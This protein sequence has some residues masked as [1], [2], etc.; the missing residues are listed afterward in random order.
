[1]SEVAIIGAGPT[2]LACALLLARLGVRSTVIERNSGTSTH[3]R[4]HVVNARSL[5]I[6]RSLG[7][8]DAIRAESLPAQRNQGVA[9]LRRLTEPAIAVLRT[10]GVPERD[11]A[12]RA[13]S[14][15]LRASCP[16]DRL[17]PILREAADRQPLIDLRFGTEVTGITQDN[18]SVTLSGHGPDGRFSLTASYLV[19]AD[20][21]RSLVREQAGI[22]MHGR[23]R[24]GRQIGI[25]F[26]ADLWALVET[27][28]YLLW[29]IY[30]AATCGVLI[31][32]DGRTRWTYNFA[33][34]P[35][36]ETADA[37]TP[38][39]CA[40]ILRHVIGRE[41]IPLAIRSILPWRMQALLA[42]QMGKG[43]IFVA[44]DAAHPLPP[45]GG[46]GMNT[47]IGDVHNLAWKLAL[48]LRGAAPQALLETYG[49]E[50]RPIAH[51]NIEQS[52][53]NAMKMAELGLSGMATAE[54][55]F[56]L[57]LDGPD[58]QAA[59]ERLRQA[60]PHLSEHFDYLG[61][62][63]GQGYASGAFV[64]D[65]LAVEPPAVGTYVP[66]ARPGYRAPHIWLH[67]GEERV[68]T[69]DL[70]GFGAFTVFATPEASAWRQ[71]FEEALARRG[72]TGRGWLVGD[73]G[74]LVDPEGEFR[75]LYGLPD[76][77]AVLVRPDG[78]VAFR[79][80]ETSPGSPQ[81]I[82]DILDVTLS[83]PIKEGE[84]R[85]AA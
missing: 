29:W 26:E 78:Y 63:F 82:D 16:Q 47:G 46:Q 35:E 18:E 48:V 49:A 52:V 13:A 45:T 56:A 67:R 68:S 1:M 81:A 19:G 76:R 24:I 44:G 77:G 62:T 22:G 42:E 53:R 27:R 23:G 9:F 80:S 21:T 33:F 61:Q 25:Y 64:S 14:P 69:I 3:P 11:A 73:G 59:S 8:E 50:R 32:L 71:G 83:G 12:Q 43:R 70:I 20:G 2:G 60:V 58:Q 40:E 30:N 6:F 55:S 31:A 4:G 74:D 51:F 85:T 54:S 75:R 72:L 17:E 10:Q 7:L 15:C 5:E 39:R 36:R 34:D 79:S 66:C 57:S 38:A 41:D 28:P 37:F 65:G 84:A